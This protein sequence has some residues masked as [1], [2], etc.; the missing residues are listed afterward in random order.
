M[1]MRPPT[2]IGESRCLGSFSKC[3]E[4]IATPQDVAFLL[5]QDFVD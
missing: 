3:A 4:L 5:D 1:E 2:P